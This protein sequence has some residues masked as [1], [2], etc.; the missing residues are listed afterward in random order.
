SHFPP[1]FFER[2][3]DAPPKKVRKIASFGALRQSIKSN[4]QLPVELDDDFL[5]PAFSADPLQ[6][7]G[8]ETHTFGAEEKRQQDRQN[9][10]KLA[11]KRALEKAHEVQ[12]PQLS[13]PE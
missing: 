8:G 9:Q 11:A 12:L 13:S 3:M 7:Q 1:A 4:E 5:T 6:L 10:Q 2:A